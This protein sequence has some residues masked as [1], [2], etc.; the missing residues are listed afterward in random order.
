MFWF[1]ID[2]VTMR[3]L[4]LGKPFRYA[5]LLLLGGCLIAGLIY[6]SIVIRA[7]NERSRPSNVHA[8]ST[9]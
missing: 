5:L 2:V 9:H 7:V 6:M 4:G 8:H 1:I 3:R